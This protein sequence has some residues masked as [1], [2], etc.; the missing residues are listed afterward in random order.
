MK[1]VHFGAGNIG[2]GFVGLLLDGAGYDLVFADVADALI[3]GLQQSD[4]Y[5]V[6]EVGDDPRTTVVRG[7]GLPVTPAPILTDEGFCYLSTNPYIRE[8]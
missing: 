8:R 6:H 2:R 3:E 4:S 7:R 5:S 1:A